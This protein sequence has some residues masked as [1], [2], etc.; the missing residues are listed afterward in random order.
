MAVTAAPPKAAPPAVRPRQPRFGARWPTPVLL[1][2]LAVAVIVLSLLYGVV[3]LADAQGR[4]QSLDQLSNSSGPL[5]AAAQ[6]LYRALSDADAT[7]TGAFLAGGLEPAAVRDRYELDVAQASRSLATAVAARDPDDLDQPDHPLVVLSMQLPVYTG[8]VETARTNNRQGLPVGAAYQR[9]AS[10]LMQTKLLPAA[11]R[12]ADSE[13]A[14]VSA[15]QNSAGAIPV[16]AILVILVLGGLLWFAQREVSRHANRVVNVGLLVAT[17]AVVLSLLWMAVGATVAISQVN[18]S[19]SDG[20]AQASV[21][22]QARV[23]LLKARADETLTVVARGTGQAYQDDYVKLTKLAGGLLAAA[24][25]H[26]SD[27]KVRT[28]VDTAVAGFTSWMAAHKTVREADDGGDY[29]RAVQLTIGGGPGSAATAFDKV[30][31][32][33]GAAIMRTRTSFQQDVATAHAAMTGLVLGT[34]LLALLAAAA[35]TYGLWQ[36]LKEYR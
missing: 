31:A 35:G 30:D 29:N 11:Q 8:L 15:D 2:G 3:G 5:S 26:A 14:Q 1:G 13:T 19:R 20:S 17:G 18:A 22:A 28:D 10:N 6:D 34:A 12:L 36:R 7:A 32:A 9:E 24:K 25:E 33:L 27:P 4:T 23:T 16:L 21:L